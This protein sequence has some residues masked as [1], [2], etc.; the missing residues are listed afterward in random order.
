MKQQQSRREE[1]TRPTTVV[2]VRVA[3]IR[4]R[5]YSNL[6]SWMQDP[7]NIYIGRGGC[8]VIDGVRFPSRSSTFANPYKIGRDGTREEVI[9]KF[10]DN[11]VTR[12]EGDTHLQEE[13]RKLKGYNLGCWC[14]PE[15]WVWEEHMGDN[16]E[17]FV[18][19]G[20]VLCQLIDQYS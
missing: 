12:L 18:C 5:G 15:D 7:N 10:R 9:Q 3:H 20:Q 4:P 8:L 17:D 19:H 2:N 14:V 6:R 11:I 13:L 16:E 1:E